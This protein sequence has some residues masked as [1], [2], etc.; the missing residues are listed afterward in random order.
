MISQLISTERIHPNQAY[1]GISKH[2]FMASFYFLGLHQTFPPVFLR[3]DPE[4]SE[5]YIMIDGNHRTFWSHHFNNG[6]VKSYVVTLED[7]VPDK[8]EEANLPL[9]SL[10]HDTG[11]VQTDS[12]SDDQ[13]VAHYSVLLRDLYNKALSHKRVTQLDGVSSYDTIEVLGA[14]KR[15][16]HF[17]AKLKRQNK[18]NSAKN[19]T[20]SSYI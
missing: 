9:R 10:V 4:E 6:K 14:S 2:P 7:L 11:S 20:R 15:L 3:I 19:K 8:L 13:L 12:C 1:V 18:E 17:L 5:K 16:I